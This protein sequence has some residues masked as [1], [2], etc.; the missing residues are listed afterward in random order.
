MPTVRFC[1]APIFSLANCFASRSFAKVSVNRANCR[2]GDD[3]S[4]ET[5]HAPGF[6]RAMTHLLHEGTV[7]KHRRAIAPGR[8]LGLRGRTNAALYIDRTVVWS[9]RSKPQILV[10]L[11]GLSGPAVMR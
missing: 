7:G 1:A 2:L 10:A 5:Y 11:P 9:V 8:A 4:N 6:F 3:V